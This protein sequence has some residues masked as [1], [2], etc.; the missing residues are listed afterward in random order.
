MKKVPLGAIIPT[1][2]VV[3]P[4]AMDGGMMLQGFGK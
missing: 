2:A 4:L 1:E 3:I